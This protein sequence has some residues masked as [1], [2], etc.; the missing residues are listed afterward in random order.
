M[1]RK[2][3]LIVNPA[4]G[5]NDGAALESLTVALAAAGLAPAT[6]TTLPDGE[7]PGRDALE[8]GAIDLLVTF[9]GD[10]SANAALPPLEG[11]AGQVLVLPGGTQNL[12]ARALH[13][14]RPA[15]EIVAA[16]DELRP[17]RRHLVRS[18]H[19]VGLCEIVIGPGAT[20]SEVREALRER[21]VAAL[22]ATATEAMTQTA[23][24]ATVRVVHPAL[25]KAEGYPA[26]RLH[27]VGDAIAVDGY[28]AESLAD[29]A[30]QGLALLQRDFR[31]GPH[32][33]LG[34]HREVLCRSDAPIE[35]MIDGERAT[36]EC[37]ERFVIA[38]FDVTLL[39]SPD[40]DRE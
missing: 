33:A 23:S 30:R 21:D 14:D 38:P 40:R 19:G 27:P 16:F 8:A 34:S 15:I 31:Q 26:I 36:G 20:W 1:A 18:R 9:T 32:D 17:T 2:V 29:Y 24:G 10:G 22:A 5:S 4:S 37:D 3:W 13:G 7:L 25:G 12:L 39:A 28:G 6:T 35:L 11:W